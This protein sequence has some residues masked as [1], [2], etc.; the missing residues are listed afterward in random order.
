MLRASLLRTVGVALLLAAGALLSPAQAECLTIGIG[1]GGVYAEKRAALVEKIFDKAGLCARPLLAPAR[2][3][4]LMEK[5]GEVDGTAWRDDPYLATHAAEAKVPTPVEHFHGS[6]FWLR[7]KEDPSGVAGATIGILA[8]RDWPRDAL[9]GQ[10]VSLFEANSYSQLFRLTE[11]GR[12]AGFVMPTGLF[13]TL[14]V[15]RT[16]YRSKVIRSVPLYLV[17]Q[18]R[19]Q[20]VIPALNDAIKALKESGALDSHS[21]ASR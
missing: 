15:D 4:D 11:S 2:R 12:L 6:L 13:E 5:R 10:P 19:H 3:L 14:D 8:G 20:D 1:T 7:S 9:K 17:V 18:R 16:L 21:P